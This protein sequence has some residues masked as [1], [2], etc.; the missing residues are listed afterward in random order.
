MNPPS[1][2]SHPSPP[3]SGFSSRLIFWWPER[4]ASFLLPGLFILAVAIHALTFYVFQVV[5]PPTV[6]IAPPP[7]QVT[8]LT[9]SSPQNAALLQWVEAQ[10][11]ALAEHL[12]ETTPAG[13]ADVA[14]VPSYATV[15]TPPKPAELAEEKRG[16]SLPAYHFAALI[17]PPATVRQTKPAS[18]RSSL[19]FSGSLKNRDAQPGQPVVAATRTAAVNL[20][21]TTFMVG[22]SDRG[23]VRYTFLQE[24]GSGDR[25]L[26][27]EAEALLLKHEFKREEGAPA[28]A[29]G[30]ATFTWGAEVFLP[31]S[32]TPAATPAPARA[33]EPPSAVSP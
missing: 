26:D 23:E 8:L 30:F 33:A 11:P 25:A 10:N 7:A 6:S 9:P 32:A 3:P 22:I 14:Y 18:V 16:D 15:R 17:A 2:G 4:S 12:Q 28:L 24:K 1:P 5:Y 19:A 21:P 27:E 20:L 29:W 13:L 31:P